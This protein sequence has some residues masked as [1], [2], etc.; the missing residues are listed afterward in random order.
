MS[1]LLLQPLPTALTR[2]GGLNP[3][4]ALQESSPCLSHTPKAHTHPA[5]CSPPCSALPGR[6]LSQG[7]P[8]L[9]PPR[10]CPPSSVPCSFLGGLRSHAPHSPAPAP[11]AGPWDP[12]GPRA[13]PAGAAL[14]A[15]R[16]NLK[17]ELA[18][19]SE[20]SA[21]ALTA[22]SA[23][24]GVQMPARIRVRPPCHSTAD[25]PPGAPVPGAPLTQGEGQEQW[26]GAGAAARGGPVHQP[27]AEGPGSPWTSLPPPPAPLPGPRAP[28]GGPGNYSLGP[29]GNE[30]TSQAGTRA[31]GQATPRAGGREAPGVWLGGGS[32]LF[33]LALSAHTPAA[34]RGTRWL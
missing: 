20:R 33:I 29:A 5:N 11:A 24:G 13:A 32:L 1:S 17:L 7:V 2:A 19:G 26:Q 23:P 16:R 14:G 12:F 6:I 9:L 30:T 27:H 3:L 18:P 15:K 8:S 34:R 31:P 25:F 22:P 10:S 21:W 4:P 28:E